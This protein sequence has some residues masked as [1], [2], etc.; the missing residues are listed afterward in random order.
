MAIRAV[1]H[2]GI[3]VSDLDRSLRFYVDGLGF[4]L[5]GA[6]GV[7]GPAWGRVME[8]GDLDVQ[9]RILR[10]DAVA[11]E[12][13]C[14]ASPGHVGDGGRRPMNELG[15]THLAV[16]VDDLDEERARLE[17]LGARVVEETLTSFDEPG[18]QARWLYCTDP[19]GVR[20]ELIEHATWQ[21][22]ALRGLSGR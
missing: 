8:V 22:A 21:P 19:D 11:I 5:L 7:S 15:L 6:F 12:L 13:L 20:I 10:R 2:V 17:R 9:S 4:E 1:T 3:C 14:F 16:W 18:L